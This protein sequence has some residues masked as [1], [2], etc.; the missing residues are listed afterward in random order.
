MMAGKRVHQ[1]N[2]VGILEVAGMRMPVVLLRSKSTV[3]L[4]RVP[5]SKGFHCRGGESQ[6][7]INIRTDEF[8]LRPRL[9]LSGIWR[10]LSEWEQRH[11]ISDRHPVKVTLLSTT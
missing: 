5:K 1:E 7:H 2:V 10:S 9:R 11:N 3:D 6:L 4:V 8:M